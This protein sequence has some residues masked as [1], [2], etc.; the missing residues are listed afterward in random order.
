MSE[1]KY[2]TIWNTVKKDGAAFFVT[3]LYGEKREKFVIG[4]KCDI[5]TLTAE[6]KVTVPKEILED[7]C[8]LVEQ[9]KKEKKVVF[10]QRKKEE[11]QTKRES[12]AKDKEEM[13]RQED[14]QI[15]VEPFCEQE[16]LILLGG[17]HVSLALASFAAKTGFLVTVVDDRPSFA[18]AVRFPFAREV[19]CDSFES[20]LEQLCITSSDYIAILTRGHRHDGV[21]L[22]NLY[23]QKNPLYIGMIGSRRRVRELKNQLMEEEGIKKEWLDQIHS[24]IGLSIGAISPEEIA[25][26]I[27]AELIQVKRQSREGYQAM[28]SD[29]DMD[30]IETLAN[31]PKEKKESKKVVA[32]V[33]ES[34]G[35]TPRKAGAKMVVYDNG[36]ID[37]TIGGGCAEAAMIQ[38]A[39]A[40][41]REAQGSYKI[42]EVDMT[43]AI[44]QEEGMVCGGTMKVLL[45]RE[46]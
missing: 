22:R 44:A 45:E 16:R 7:V 18:N 32:T 2:E 29:I 36:A 37:G 4:N 19:I 23:K 30:V 34:K 6:Q 41:L 40:L 20:A 28:Q 21:C 42:C 31:V 13:P 1:Q 35:S 11:G 25:V 26:S 33:L 8:S 38:D 9:S 10:A 5:E 43:G 46:E 3:I 12:E 17:G 14:V 24:P 39:R 15:V 27:L